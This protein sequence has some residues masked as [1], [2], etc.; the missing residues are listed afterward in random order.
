M[1]RGIGCDK[2]SKADIKRRNFQGMEGLN[3]STGWVPWRKKGQGHGMNIKKFRKLL[4]DC[5]GE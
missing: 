2:T 5:S 3:N 4:G 1:V